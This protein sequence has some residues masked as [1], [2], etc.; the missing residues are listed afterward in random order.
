MTSDSSGD[1]KVPELLPESASE[2]L[3]LA[4]RGEGA[5]PQVDH[6][7]NLGARAPAWGEEGEGTDFSQYLAAV[8]R[9]KWIVALATVVG[10]AGGFVAARLEKP[11]Y[12]VE[13]TVWVEPPDRTGGGPIQSGQLLFNQGWIELL[14]SYAVLDGAVEELGLYL[15]VRSDDSAAFRAF[16]VSPRFVPGKY[17]LV[18]DDGGAW[19]TLATVEGI[20]LER[21]AVGDSI[22]GDLGF[23][24]A[25]PPGQLRA[26]RTIEFSLVTPRDAARALGERLRTRMD[27]EGNFLRAQLPGSR[28]IRLA[29]TLNMVID[30]FVAVAA[31][32][33]REKLTAFA[34]VLGEQLEQA[35]VDLQ[36]SE[37]AL[38]T[39]RM[40]TIGLPGD[41]STPLGPGLSLRGDSQPGPANYFEM[42]IAL[43]QLRSDRA[44]IQHVLADTVE[45][46]FS[47][48]ALEGLATV[49]GSADLTSVLTEV[50]ARR[51]ELRQLRLRYT[52]EHPVVQQL[53][54]E[55]DNLAKNAVVPLAREL[56]VQLEAQE[57]Q[58]AARL[59]AAAEQLEQIPA[60]L[61]EEARLQ[62]D[63]AISAV[64][65]NTLQQRYTEA[66][67]AE[68]SSIPDVR[69]LD[70]A[71]VPVRPIANHVL[72]FLMIGLVG[73][74]GLG[75]VGAVLRDRF[76]ARVQYPKEVSTE[77]G[78]PVLGAVP[79]LR[80]KR[81]GLGAGAE[82]SV[83][84][85][86]RGVRLNLI[87]AYGTAGP[88]IV[89]I[90][91]PG[92]RDGK[93]FISSNLALAF[94]DAGH[95]TLLVDGDSRRGEL[96]RVLNR[97]RKPGLTDCL[98][99][100]VS[101]GDIV[102]RTDYRL[103]D[104]IGCGTRTAEAPELLGSAAMPQLIAKVRSTYDVLL[105]DSPPLGAGVDAFALATV[106]G[107]VMIVLRMG[108][109]DRALTEAK[110]DV[111]DRL[112]VRV[113]GA[114]LNGVRQGS[115]SSYYSYYLPGY[116]HEDEGGFMRKLIGSSR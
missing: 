101:P 75:L 14:K 30:R 68:E 16:D 105:L 28:P 83:V 31:E 56:A 38:Q 77:L 116:E 15:N 26:G 24:W 22:G 89:T 114:V 40:Q 90:T 39:L 55:I 32:L 91:S 2:P 36:A 50:T 106:S 61:I 12:M 51:A 20:V 3:G 93:S 1:G 69:V 78:L 108:V 98:A 59:E 80:G 10:V 94:T 97:E 99:G 79:H 107:N 18:V 60:R 115:E 88:I 9:H 81:D 17:R 47:P 7:P 52:D 49:Q 84:E 64:L 19:V 96:H 71:V 67:L 6:S 57:A 46:G 41:A 95:R 48:A 85:S 100:T 109:T 43:D 33:K 112:P 42:Q 13:S 29:R 104:F 4:Q 21:A 65:Y 72:Q 35:R 73:G 27:R 53:E 86:L 70:P 87:H 63:V 8:M 111:L 74:L 34:T 11:S 110:L 45:P 54:T 5:Y 62:R 76:D 92:A 23:G 37:T 103:L 66:R 58:Y 25:P 44:A 113:L 102:Q 82:N